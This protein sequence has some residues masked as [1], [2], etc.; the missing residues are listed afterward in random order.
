MGRLNASIA[1]LS[2]YSVVSSLLIRP[3]GILHYHAEFALNLTK[4][5]AMGYTPAFV[6]YGREP[7][8]SLEH[9]V[10]KVTNCPVASVSDKVTHMQ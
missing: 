10:C 4:S 1:A 2:R 7:M 3:T 9:A 5:A 6:L 8:L